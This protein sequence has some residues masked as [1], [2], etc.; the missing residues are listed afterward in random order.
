MTECRFCMAITTNGEPTDCYQISGAGTRK[1]YY[2]CSECADAL[3][4][5][6]L[7]VEVVR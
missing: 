7:S 4:R 2:L 3:E 6:G 5:L 1:S